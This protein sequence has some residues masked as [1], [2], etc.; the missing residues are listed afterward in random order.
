MQTTKNIP[1]HKRPSPLDLARAAALRACLKGEMLLCAALRCRIEDP[2]GLRLD[3]ET[4]RL[5]QNASG[6]T[7]GNIDRALAALAEAG[8]IRIEGGGGMVRVRILPREE[9]I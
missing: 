3:A 8:E 6:L 4:Y 7:R 2:A 9:G 5:L 1:L